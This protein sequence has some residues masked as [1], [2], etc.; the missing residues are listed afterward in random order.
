MPRHTQKTDLSHKHSSA[1]ACIKEFAQRFSMAHC[2]SEQS[3]PEKKI[4]RLVPACMPAARSAQSSRSGRVVST[5][6]SHACSQVKNHP[7]RCSVFES[8]MNCKVL[9]SRHRHAHCL[10]FCC[11]RLTSKC[12]DSRMCS[13][14]SSVRQSTAFGQQL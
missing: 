1:D 14:Q 12:V 8:R 3:A 4:G 5:P 11:S 6:G 2:T 7:Y 13:R 9:H 10:L